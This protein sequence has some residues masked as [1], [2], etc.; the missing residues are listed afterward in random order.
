[1]NNKLSNKGILSGLIAAAYIV[2]V[3]AFMISAESIFG[4]KE[5]PIL[6]VVLMLML[7]VFSAAVM[8]VV[9]FGR[10]VMMYLDGQKKEAVK[11]LAW[12]LGSFFCLG[13][14]IGVIVAVIR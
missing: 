2:A 14:M 5:S 7:F 10:P 13:I 1:M 4:Q 12:S 3:A 6:G 11:L 9:L 8:F